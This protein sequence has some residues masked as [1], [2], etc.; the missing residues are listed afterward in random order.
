MRTLQLLIQAHIGM[1]TRTIGDNAQVQWRTKAAINPC[2]HTV[3]AFILSVFYGNLH[4]A[5][6]QRH[7]FVQEEILFYLF[8]Y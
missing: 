6:G 2:T 7:R 5:R 3:Y 8:I 1:E 4:I